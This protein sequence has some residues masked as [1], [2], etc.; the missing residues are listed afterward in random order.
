METITVRT[1]EH[2]TLK[3]AQ[4]M[5]AFDEPIP[6]FA[7]RYPNR[8][9]SCLAT[10][11]QTFAKKSLYSSLV[12]KASILFYLMI[13]NHPF[14]NGNKRIAMTTLLVFLFL[15]KKWIQVDT[16]EL[17]NFTVWIAQSPPKLKNEVVKAIEKF[18]KT[19]LVQIDVILDEI[20]DDEDMKGIPF[21]ELRKK[22]GKKQ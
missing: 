21:E 5:L 15:N 16:Q 9:E 11:F 12:S 10:P 2:L 13:K 3:L 7:T 1:V 14:Q 8:L 6:D 22:R 20:K 4:E 17:Y 19:Y 18:I